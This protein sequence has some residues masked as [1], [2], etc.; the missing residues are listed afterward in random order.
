MGTISE[1]AGI[2]ELDSPYSGGEAVDIASTDH[3]FTKPTRAIWVGTGGAVDLKVTM[4][5]GG[6]LTFKTVASGT[7]LLIRTTKVIKVGTGTSN[8]MGLW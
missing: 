4:L 6:D 8:M 7:L 5:G 1:C 2:V 3:T